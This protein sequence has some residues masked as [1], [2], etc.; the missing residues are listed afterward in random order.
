MATPTIGTLTEQF[1]CT[2]QTVA[3]ALRLLVDEGELIRY[4]GFGY[5]VSWEPE[6]DSGG[7][8]ELS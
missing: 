5:F 1:G 2:R 4:P 3:K 6:A 7:S 8:G